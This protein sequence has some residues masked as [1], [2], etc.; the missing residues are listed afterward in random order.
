MRTAVVVRH[1]AFTPLYLPLSVVLPGDA[2]I[3]PSHPPFSPHHTQ[4]RCRPDK[5]GNTVA[6]SDSRAC[7]G[8][9]PSGAAQHGGICVAA[10]RGTHAV[11]G[12]V[13]KSLCSSMDIPRAQAVWQMDIP[14][15]QCA[16]RTTAGHARVS[17]QLLSTSWQLLSA[18]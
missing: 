13:N 14:H 6:R 12:P 11:T 17:W 9:K 10:P 2:A 15:K 3:L 18:S 1:K 7:C 8:Q 16:V 4:F 5:C